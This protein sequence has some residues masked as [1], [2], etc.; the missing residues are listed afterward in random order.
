MFHHRC[1]FEGFQT[2]NHRLQGFKL[3]M[4]F[5]HIVTLIA[6]LKL[7]VFK[8]YYRLAFLLQNSISLIDF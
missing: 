6:L 4:R 2:R 7:A 3:N 8:Q 5:N 1:D